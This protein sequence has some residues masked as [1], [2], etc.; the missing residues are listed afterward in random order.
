MFF[1]AN[2]TARQV[3]IIDHKYICHLPYSGY[4]EHYSQMYLDAVL[5]QMKPPSG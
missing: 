1:Y 3:G 5:R 4:I 2:Y